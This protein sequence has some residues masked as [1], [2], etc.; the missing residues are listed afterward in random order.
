[1]TGTTA[2]EQ[3]MQL[4]SR[5]TD[6]LVAYENDVPRKLFLQGPVLQTLVDIERRAKA[7]TQDVPDEVIEDLGYVR[8]VFDAFDGTTTQ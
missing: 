4:R 5:L 3:M 1:M 8:G 2:M 6:Q 7:V